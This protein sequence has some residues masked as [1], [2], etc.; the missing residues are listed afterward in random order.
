MQFACAQ[1]GGFCGLYYLL[2]QRGISDS[3]LWKLPLILYL[4]ADLPHARETS[5]ELRLSQKALLIS[6]LEGFVLSTSVSPLCTVI[7]LF[8]HNST[9]PRSRRDDRQLQEGN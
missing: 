2:C 7:E 4:T 6:Q 5:T 3:L 9:E 8:A 1:Q